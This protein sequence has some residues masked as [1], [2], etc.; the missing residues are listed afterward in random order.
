MDYHLDNKLKFSTDIEHSRL[1]KWCLRE[2]DE[3]GNQIGSDQIPWHWSINFT[4]TDFRYFF[5]INQERDYDL[6]ES[7][8]EDKSETKTDEDIETKVTESITASLSPTKDSSRFGSYT[9]YSMFATNREIT[10]FNLRIEKSEEESCWISGSVSYTAEHDFRD[11]TTDDWIEII[12]LLKPDN[13]EKVV[14]LIKSDTINESYL[15]LSHTDGFYSEWSPSIS[16]DNV[17]VLTRS[18]DQILDIPEDCKIEPPR[19]GKVGDLDLHLGHKHTLLIKEDKNE[20]DWLDE[21]NFVDEEHEALLDPEAH[22]RKEML[23]SV[24]NLSAGLGRIRNALVVVA[25]ILIISLF[26]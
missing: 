7:D 15:R 11:E 3:N 19:L 14:N 18:D 9:T 24:S 8:D 10:E 16:T 1:Y 21:D 17:K 22:F 23:G 13:F 25:V 6:F 26:V 20:G 4:I 2:F 5:N 12:L